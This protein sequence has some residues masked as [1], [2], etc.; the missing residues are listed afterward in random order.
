MKMV[1]SLLL[2]SAAGVV[3][4]AGAQAA[5]LP[6]KAKP[7]Q[8]VK[9]CTLYGDGFY[10]IPGSDT[11]IRFSGYIRADYGYNVTGARTAN[12]AAG[13]GAQDRTTNNYSTRHRGSFSVDTRT[14]TAYGTLRTFQTH[15][16]QNE[17][18]SES[19]NIARAFIQWG[20]FTFGRTVSFTDHEGSLGDSGMRSLHQT[21]NQSDTGANG[22]NQI[23]YT[24]QLGNG[25]TLNVGADE[26]RVKSLVNL[27]VPTTFAGGGTLNSGAAVGL[28]PI[29]ARDGN[30]HPNPW[31]S[32]RINQ[33]WGRA[34]VAVIANHNEGAYY[35]AGAAPVPCAQ[36]TP[37]LSMVGNT[38]C[39][40]PDGKWGFAVISGTEIKLDMLS[41]GSRLG[42]Y[43]NYGVGASAYGGG[44]NL[45]S[46][47]L[48]GSGNEVALGFITDGVFLNN[49]S[50][51]QTTT[52]TAGGG[53]EYFWTRNFSS[54]IY[55]NYTEVSYNDTVNAGRLWCTA[56][57][58]GAGFTK[59]TG[60][61]DFGFKYWTVG[62]H[63]DWF[64]L[65]G[66]R[67]AVD[68]M[69]TG[70]DSNMSGETIS[71]VRT[72]GAR[73]PGVYTIKDLGIVSTIFRAQRTWGAD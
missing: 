54:T 23:A 45:V 40:H 72:Q 30:N 71:I 46:P 28:E 63:H 16:M 62:T 55:G 34:S 70:I 19:T 13:A 5:D 73:V 39:G 17:N 24:W 29:S 50:I 35:G 33:A 43:F 51:Q 32:L 22:T 42:A 38:N 12:Y 6:V 31:V 57:I 11:C 68:V 7:V 10:Y 26:R 18:G 64:P 8:Y 36:Q 1:K 49:G 60:A 61:C 4:I 2:G 56:G 53:F 25:I 21:Q 48:Y 67:F 47:G 9:I 27:S 59:T 52:W 37:P 41:P 15:H 66:L 44:S 69:Y 65:P 20:G 14:Q 3:A 58:Q